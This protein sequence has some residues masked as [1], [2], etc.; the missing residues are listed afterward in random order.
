MIEI[1]E[2]R[3]GGG[4]SYTAVYRAMVHFLKGGTVC[5]NIDLN[6][7]GCCAYALKRFG[8]QLERDQF[9]FLPDE[10]IPQFHKYTPSGTGELPVLVIIDEAPLNFDSRDFAQN[11]KENREVYTFSRQSRKTDTDVI[12]IAQDATDLD[13]KLRNLSQYIWRF[14]DLSK[15][16]IPGL[17]I[18]FPF[19]M[20]LCVQMDYDGRTMLDKHF[21][22]K[23]RGIFA[24]YNTRSLLRRFERLEGVVTKRQLKR[25]RRPFP[26]KPV[27]SGLLALDV[28]LLLA[29]FYF[30]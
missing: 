6:W 5:T 17:G 13:K 4:K 22:P 24:C 23:D 18:R 19:N 21:V 8:L 30:A 26:F 28:L 14:R 25:V 20:I 27:A 1:F 16:K 12:L 10:Q 15:W 9:I 29:V 11:Y 2:G 3:L 7:A